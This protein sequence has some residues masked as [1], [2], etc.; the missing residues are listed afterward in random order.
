LK[1]IPSL[2]NQSH[3]IVGHENSNQ[4]LPRPT[5]FPGSI[6]STGKSLPNPIKSKLNNDFPKFTQLL[7]N[8]NPSILQK[9]EKG[10]QLIVVF[11]TFPNPL[12]KTS[13]STK[14][15]DF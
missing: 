13:L 5:S 6:F 2:Q 11:L 15:I 1:N 9:M 3:I 14:H 10:S 12:Y 8:T 7:T 4:L